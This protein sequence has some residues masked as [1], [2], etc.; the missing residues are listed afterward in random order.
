MKHFLNILFLIILSQMAFAQVPQKISFQSVIRQQSGSLLADAQVGARISIIRTSPGGTVYRETVFPNPSTN[1]NGLLTFEIGEGNCDICGFADIDWSVGTY[2]IQTEIDPSGGINYTLNSTTALN[3]VPFA[4]YSANGVKGDPGA[5]GPPGEKGEKGDPGMQGERGERG[6]R[7]EKGDTGNPGE[8]GDPGIPGPSGPAGTYLAGAGIVIAGDTL[9]ALDISDTN[10]IQT[11]SLIGTVLSLSKGGGMVQLPTPSGG[12][13]WGNQAVISNSTLT[14][15]G[16]N[17]SPLGIA[18]QGANNGQVLKFNGTSWVPQFDTWGNQSVEVSNRLFGNGTPASPLDIAHMNATNGQVLKWSSNNNRWEPGNDIAGLAGS[19]TAGFLPVWGLNG[20][21][22]NS[23]I[24]QETAKIII[25]DF[26]TQFRGTGAGDMDG[27]FISPGGNIVDITTLTSD[28]YIQSNGNN[29]IILNGNSGTGRVGIGTAIPS[30]KLQVIGELKIGNVAFSNIG[31]LSMSNGVIYME[32]THAT[33]G[34]NGTIERTTV[35]NMEVGCNWL[36]NLNNERSLG[37]A[38]KRWNTVYA[39]NSMINTSDRR[40]KKDILPIQ[41]GLN[42]VLAMKPVS[43]HWKDDKFDKST[44][45]G[46]IAQELQTIIKE[47]V[48]DSETTF[49]DNRNPITTATEYLGVAYNE[50]TPVLVRAIQ[51][52]QEIIENLKNQVE[53]LNTQV[54]KLKLLEIKYESQ[55]ASIEKLLKFVEGKE[56]NSEMGMNK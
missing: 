27:I 14:G 21:L 6:E 22:L 19:G 15:N 2:Y 26:D 12:D 46:F 39:T 13:D 29:D 32:G 28:L 51:E 20:T 16:T 48:K 43:Y 36:P 47:V 55:Q 10:E 18:A 24:K 33:I 23:R 49:D 40:L 31:T 56:I 5:P 37:S 54:G 42:E 7:G 52:Q 8:D 25:E 11:I 45:L 35:S 3:S 50:I 53:S 9:R 34:V 44:K 30:S 38:S 1:K 41:Y 4:L 17:A